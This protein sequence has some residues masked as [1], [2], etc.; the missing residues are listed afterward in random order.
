MGWGGGGGLSGFRV[1]SE[2][3]D[4]GVQGLRHISATVST[5]AQKGPLM[6]VCVCI[7]IYIY[8]CVCVNMKATDPLS[9]TAQLLLARGFATCWEVNGESIPRR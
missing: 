1:A 6:Y 2:G 3:F 7:Y 9:I 5:W 8:V 4:L